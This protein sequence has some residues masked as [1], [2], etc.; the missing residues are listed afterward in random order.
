MIDDNTRSTRSRRLRLAL[1]ILVIL[2]IYMGV[3]AWFQRD[4]I[5][6]VAPTGVAPLIQVNDI[7][8]Q[9]VQWSSYADRPVLV[10]FWGTWCSVCAA[11]RPTINAVDKNWDVLSI[12]LQSGDNQALTAFLQEHQINWRTVNDPDGGLSRQ[13]AV[14][15]VPTSFILKN[16]RIIFAQRGYIT[17]IGLRLRLLAAKHFY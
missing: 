3:Q 6:R 15:A 7:A 4:L 13:Y 8:G 5:N 1:K 10:H 11:E 9:A 2:L 16:G 12:A 14:K 17:G